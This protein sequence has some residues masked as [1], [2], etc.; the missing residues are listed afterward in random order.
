MPGAEVKDVKDVKEVKDGR[1]SR[2][3]IRH[4]K[5]LLIYKQAYR[6]ALEVSKLVKTFPRQ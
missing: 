6:L 5:D 1:E 4:Y 2:A 3:P